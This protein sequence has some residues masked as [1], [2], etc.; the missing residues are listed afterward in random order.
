MVPFDSAERYYFIVL[1]V[2]TTIARKINYKLCLKV[3]LNVFQF[4]D[5]F[6]QEPHNGG[7]LVY[8]LA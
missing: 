5:Q 7:T 8:R 3:L 4:V 2:H 1:K 6:Q